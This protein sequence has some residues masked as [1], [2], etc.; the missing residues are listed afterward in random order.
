MKRT[1]FIL[2]LLFYLISC[3]SQEYYPNPDLVYKKVETTK[4]I[5]IIDRQHYKLCEGKKKN[6]VDIVI[7]IIN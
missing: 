4:K 7:P 3:Y 5:R 1:Y 2:G 6:C